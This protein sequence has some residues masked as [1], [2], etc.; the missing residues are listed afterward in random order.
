MSDLDIRQAEE[1]WTD[2]TLKVKEQIAHWRGHGGWT[3]E[4]WDEV[5][6]KTFKI[7]QKLTEQVSSWEGSK[8]RIV[9]Y[10]CGG[11]PQLF[12]F[13]GFFPEMVGVDVSR[14]TLYEATNEL[15]V[16]QKLDFTPV[17]IDIPNP[18]KLLELYDAY[19]DFFLSIAVWQHLPNRVYARRI[20]RIAN[21]VLR[22]NGRAVVMILQ[23]KQRGGDYSTRWKRSVVLTPRQAKNDFEEFGF[24]ILG[25]ESLKAKRY[26]DNY[27]LLEKV[28]DYADEEVSDAV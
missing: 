7:Y 24:T 14:Q 23:G 18:E 8:D 13:S 10:G 4:L 6:Q 22:I 3:P 1:K 20:L 27:Y 17:L 5:G 9:E 2:K 19:F 25:C 15:L 26:C 11:G 21:R 16:K 28:S 12:A